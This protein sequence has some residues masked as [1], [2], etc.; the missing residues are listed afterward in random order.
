[1]I[2]LHLNLCRPYLE[3]VYHLYIKNVSDYGN[4]EIVIPLS[5]LFREVVASKEGCQERIS[6]IPKSECKFN[7][8]Q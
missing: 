6:A 2:S 3:L 7:E 4:A 1:M 8:A 5:E